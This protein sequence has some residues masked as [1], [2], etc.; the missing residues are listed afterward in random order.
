MRQTIVPPVQR[1]VQ[2]RGREFH[3]QNTPLQTIGLFRVLGQL[4]RGRELVRPSI[5]PVRIKLGEEFDIRTPGNQL[6]RITA[7]DHPAAVLP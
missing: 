6:Q 4:L 5:A 2:R 7:I 1:M 3:S